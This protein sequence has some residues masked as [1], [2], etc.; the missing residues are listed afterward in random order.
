[1][2]DANRPNYFST[3]FIDRVSDKRQDDEWLAA[4]PEFFAVIQ[5]PY[6]VAL[7][8]TQLYDSQFHG[9]PIAS[10]YG[11]FFPEA[12]TGHEEDLRAFPVNRALDVLLDWGVRYVLLRPDDFAGWAGV[13]RTIAAQPRLRLAYDDGA[14][15]AYEL[16]EWRP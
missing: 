7:E 14:V 6:E 15:R 5:L 11:S 9:K 16:T 13:E 1:M 12:F 4:Q 8:G 3:H 2:I 10:G